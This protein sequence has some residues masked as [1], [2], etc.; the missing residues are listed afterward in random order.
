VNV[1]LQFSGAFEIIA[2]KTDASTNAQN[3]VG[4]NMQPRHDH[5]IA[6]IALINKQP[7]ALAQK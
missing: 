4:L 2:Q 7:E 1:Q 5:M 3:V 6:K